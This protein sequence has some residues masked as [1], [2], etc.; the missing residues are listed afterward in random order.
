MLPWP[1]WVSAGTRHRISRSEQDLVQELLYFCP[2]AA[3]VQPLFVFRMGTGRQGAI[4]P[5]SRHR[6]DDDARSLGNV[7]GLRQR[8]SIEIGPDG[9]RDA[10]HIARHDGHAECVRLRDHYRHTVGPGR[11]HEKM[12]LREKTD[13]GPPTFERLL[14]NESTRRNSIAQRGWRIAADNSE[15]RLQPLT[16]E[17]L[18]KLDSR[19]AALA[20]PID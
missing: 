7:A 2:G 19:V 1:R 14:G 13:E 6:L 12:R 8:V 15:S 5:W 18:Q 10:S 16:I 11:Q 4:R 3:P 17:R 20:I 9:R